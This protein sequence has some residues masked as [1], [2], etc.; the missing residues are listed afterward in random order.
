MALQL[1]SLQRNHLC[2]SDFA[3]ISKDD[4]MLPIL[5]FKNKIT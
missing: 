1:L 5:V 2:R 4:L 3:M